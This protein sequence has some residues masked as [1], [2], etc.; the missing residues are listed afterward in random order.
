MIIESMRITFL[1]FITF[2]GICFSENKFAGNT[3]YNL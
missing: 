2:S 1:A 3:E